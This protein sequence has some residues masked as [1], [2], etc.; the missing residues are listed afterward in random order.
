L[1]LIH[2]LFAMIRRRIAMIYL[3]DRISTYER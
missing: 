2:L 3:K 1:D